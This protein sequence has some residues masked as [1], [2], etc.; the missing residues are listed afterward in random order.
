MEARFEP[1]G[2]PRLRIAA[3]GADREPGRDRAPVLE[4]RPDGVGGELVSRDPG[5]DALDAGQPERLPAPSASA[6]R[7]FSIFQPKAS[8]PISDA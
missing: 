7:S 3:V 5:R 8:S 6:I 1:G 4:P 2:A